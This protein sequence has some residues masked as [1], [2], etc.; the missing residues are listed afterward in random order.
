MAA[1][2]ELPRSIFVNDSAEP[3]QQVRLPLEQQHEQGQEQEEEKQHEQGQEQEEEKQHEHGQ[4]Q[5]EE[6]QH[7][8]GQEQEEE[9]PRAVQEQEGSQQSC[10][11]SRGRLYKGSS[12][13]PVE[14]MWVEHPPGSHYYFATGA[15]AFGT[16]KPSRQ[17]NVRVN[18][19]AEPLVKHVTKRSDEIFKE[20]QTLLPGGVNSPVRAFR[21]VGGQPIVFDRVKGAYAWD[22]DSNKYID[23]NVMAKMVIERVP[24]VEMVRFVSSGTEAC[25]SVLRLMRA[26][27]KREKILKFVGCYH[28]HA[29]SFLVKAGSGVATLGL[30]DSPGDDVMHDGSLGRA[31]YSG[32]VEH[33]IAVTM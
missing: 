11:G 8:Q 24:S 22:V 27:T 15:Q 6:K 25:L 4:E 5:E 20:A 13:E 17:A 9:K 29:D 3:Q 1:D 10:S 30:P 18:A 32:M 7:E 21:S 23:Y 2:D 28:G 16:A 14:V 31:C 33:V 26:Y 19:I 12:P